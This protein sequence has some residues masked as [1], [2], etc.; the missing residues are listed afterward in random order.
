MTKGVWRGV[1][2]SGSTDTG[3]VK[4]TGLDE[5]TLAYN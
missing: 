4:F 2:V 5:E 1:F 3:P